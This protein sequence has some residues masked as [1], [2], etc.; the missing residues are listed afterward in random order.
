MAPHDMLLFYGRETN[1]MK[2]DESSLAG[3]VDESSLAGAVDDDE[4]DAMWD[5]LDWD[6]HGEDYEPPGLDP[7]Y[8]DHVHRFHGV[9]PVGCRIQGEVVKRFLNFA[10]PHYHEASED[11][12]H[13]NVNMVRNWI[14]DRIPENA[15][16]FASLPHGNYLCF[17]YDDDERPSIVRWCHERSEPGTPSLERVAP[18]FDEFLMNL[19]LEEG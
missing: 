15:I 5:H 4:I 16:P 9:K 3:E 11:I 12:K 6:E 8:Q 19:E 17:L 7:A 18:D 14:A 13:H 2:Y 10:N 1:L